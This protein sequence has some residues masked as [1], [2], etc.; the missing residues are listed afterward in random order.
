A[1]GGRREKKKQSNET[2]KVVGVGGA[3]EGGIDSV[4]LVVGTEKRAATRQLIEDV[5][6]PEILSDFRTPAGKCTKSYQ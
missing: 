4:R 2:C 3:K 1:V 6:M 5:V